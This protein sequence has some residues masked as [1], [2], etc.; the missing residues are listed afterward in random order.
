MY[1]IIA[2]LNEIA[3]GS[4]TNTG[5]W[6]ALKRFYFLYNDGILKIQLLLNRCRFLV[7]RRTDISR[8]L[9]RQSASLSLM[10][11]YTIQL[12][13]QQFNYCHTFC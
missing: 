2:I 1:E 8:L 12:N 10:I 6:T 13:H 4:M 7:I 11:A 5:N 3:N 9:F